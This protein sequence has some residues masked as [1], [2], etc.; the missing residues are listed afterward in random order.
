[1]DQ[2]YRGGFWVQPKDDA[3]GIKSKVSIYLERKCQCLDPS[4]ALPSVAE[5]KVIGQ[6]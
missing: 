6:F 2:A 5:V 3:T 4:A 1:M